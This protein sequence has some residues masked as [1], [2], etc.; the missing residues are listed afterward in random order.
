MDAY[1]NY[2]IEG[3]I[4]LVI[5]MAAYALILRK[6]TDFRI[7]RIFL[8]TGVLLSATLPLVHV[9]F[10]S[11]TISQLL[12]VYKLS[13]VIVS[14]TGAQKITTT[15]TL[16]ALDFW[17]SVQW[18]YFFGALYFLLRFAVDMIRL[19]RL[20]WNSKWSQQGKLK[21][22]ECN[23][24][25]QALS[26]FNFVIIGQA[27]SLPVSDKEKV[28]AH[29]IAHAQQLHSLDVIIL[30]VVNIIFWFNPVLIIY[31]RIFVQLHEFEADA[32]A[33][34]NRD[35]NE[36]CSLL[37]KVALTSAG[38]N[39]AN[40]F[41]H[42]LTLKRIEMMR[43]I[44]QKISHWKLAATIAVM[45]VVF[46]VV[47]CQDQ[48]VDKDIHVSID[49]AAVPEGGNE[50]FYR[51]LLGQLKY[52][53]EARQKRITGTVLVE[54]VINIDGSVE[55]TG[56]SGTGSGLDL[57]SMRVVASSPKW[58][59]ALKNGLAVRE[60]KIIPV[61]FRL[62]EVPPINMEIPPGALNSIFVVGAPVL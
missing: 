24:T 21:I 57:E 18:I 41:N 35:V 47:A 14:D 56:V 39:L 16:T 40:H 6:E 46:T 29:E 9:E 5:F 1:V 10:G 11:T 54:F 7:Q 34:E 50:T 15:G 23:E 3:N 58:K 53:E 32:R 27:D 42:S 30:S 52:P 61:M 49:Q 25:T 31:K 51:H 38:F 8:L 48:L 4:S 19:L 26:F 22:V 20:L 37:A 62:A 59:P 12:P 17:V 45:P 55:V 13:E 28:I 33:V 60:K 36:Y 2:V 44:K 43:T